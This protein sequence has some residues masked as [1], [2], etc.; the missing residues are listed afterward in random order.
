MKRLLTILTVLLLTLSLTGLLAAAS[1]AQDL[2]EDG[3]VD[4]SDLKWLL[5][6]LVGNESLPEGV[7]EADLDLNGNGRVDIHEAVLILRYIEGIIPELPGQDTI[8]TWERKVPQGVTALLEGDVYRFGETFCGYSNYVVIGEDGQA[9]F[10]WMAEVMPITDDGRVYTNCF[11]A[12]YQVYVGTLAPTRG[13]ELTF[14]PQKE[15]ALVQVMGGTPAE[16]EQAK[17]VLRA[18][19]FDYDDLS[20]EEQAIADAILE[21]VVLDEDGVDPDRTYG[22]VLNEDGTVASAATYDGGRL[23]ATQVYTHVNGLTVRT[24]QFN[25]EG[26]SEGYITYTYHENGTSD[27]LSSYGADGVINGSRYKDERGNIV[28]E[29]SYQNGIPEAFYRVTY[30]YNEEG[31]LVRLCRYV[32]TKDGT[33]ALEREIEWYDDGDVRSAGYYPDGTLSEE[34]FLY[35][36]GS[37]ESRSYDEKGQLSYESAY[38]AEGDLKYTRSYNEGVLV[39]QERVQ[40]EVTSEGVKIRRKYLFEAGEAEY[41]SEVTIYHPDGSVRHEYYDPAGELTCEREDTAEGWWEKRYEGG[42]LRE[43]SGGDGESNY[44]RYYD[45]EGNFVDGYRTESVFEGDRMVERLEYAYSSEGEYL[46]CRTEYNERS[47]TVRT[48]YY[49][50]DGSVEKCEWLEVYTEDGCE[51]RISYEQ[52]GDTEP[53]IVSRDLYYENGS[54]RHE[55]YQEG[56]LVRLEGEEEGRYYYAHYEYQ[57][58]ECGKWLRMVYGRMDGDGYYDVS[59]YPNGSY[60]AY[61]FQGEDGTVERREYYPDGTLRYEEATLADGSRYNKR[62]YEA[63]KLEYESCRDARGDVLFETYYDADGNVT[64]GVRYEYEYSED[65]DLL[66]CRRYETDE[67]G[68][69]YLARVTEYTENGTIESSYDSEGNLLERTRRETVYD[70]ATGI[71]QEYTFKQ[72]GGKEEFLYSLARY[73][74]YDN[75][76]Y[77]IQM[78]TDGDPVYEETFSD[79]G[80]EADTKEWRYEYDA[81]GNKYLAAYYEG[82]CGEGNREIYYLP[83]GTVVYESYYYYDGRFMTHEKEFHD[84]G[85]LRREAYKDNDVEWWKEHYEDGTLYGE[86]YQETGCNGVEKTYYENGALWI[87]QEYDPDGYLLKYVEYD[88]NGSVVG[89]LRYEFDYFGD[90]SYTK[91]RYSLNDDGLE[92][93]N[94]EDV[95]NAQHELVANKVYELDRDGNPYLYREGRLDEN[96]NW[97]DLQYDLNDDGESVVLRESFAGADGSYSETEYYPNGVMAQKYYSDG[98]GNGYNRFYN[99]NGVLTYEERWSEGE[100]TT[101]LSYDAEGNVV[102]YSRQLDYPDEYGNDL[103]FDRYELDENG[104]EYLAE[105]LRNDGEVQT[106]RQYDPA[107]TLIAQRESAPGYQKTW[108]YANDG[109][110][111]YLLEYRCF[112]EDGSNYMEQYR[113]NGKLEKTHSLDANGDGTECLYYESGALLYERTFNGNEELYKGYDEDGN[114]TEHTRTVQ[115]YGE[116]FDETRIYTLLADVEYLSRLER[117]YRDGSVESYGYDADGDLIHEGKRD[118]EGYAYQ[119]Y[120]FAYDGLGEKHL[121]E[122]SKHH[123]DGSYGAVTYYPD[124]SVWMEY[125]YDCDQNG[126]DK[127]YHENGVLQYECYTE[128]GVPVFT[129]EYDEAGNLISSQEQAA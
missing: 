56:D 109:D 7:T 68:Y 81:Q 65:G 74:E 111:V 35:A 34:Q 2:N 27:T 78:D 13:G 12:A 90:G 39:R 31:K 87:E 18:Y 85:N 54:W 118:S 53:R 69:E 29:K 82:Y 5:A 92:W 19:M 16:Q 114:L 104:N 17:D 37:R 44:H 120:T 101:Y 58:D 112:Y 106:Q 115:E 71:T 125:F 57:W 3:V 9:L 99:E 43:E 128:W 91:R 51:I 28:G 96:G 108:E 23:A 40:T 61:S 4:E 127:R 113:S 42:I 103:G 48:T 20:P 14:V 76:L 80:W 119:T 72:Y 102:S 129:A 73:D 63:G 79:D 121:H 55:E 8:P 25:G 126:Y 21:G 88:M 95:Y 24:E 123:A 10:A 83:D 116:E 47:E 52:Y 77:S 117:Y 62:Y 6:Y 41:L 66:A 64:Y 46:H 30:D 50:P 89:H 36:D 107:G 94:Y 100:G 49:N 26:E 67:N 70:E 105:S 84:N 110:G 38:D 22:L 98:N 45:E 11:L 60:E 59:Y 1:P 122:H 32:G 86:F 33:E 15:C 124:G 97:T 93:M 75:V